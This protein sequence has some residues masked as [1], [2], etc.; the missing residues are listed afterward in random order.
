MAGIPAATP[1]SRA[2][3]QRVVFGVQYLI[4]QRIDGARVRWGHGAHHRYRTPSL[5]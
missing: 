1:A 2:L 3:D 4:E 5:E